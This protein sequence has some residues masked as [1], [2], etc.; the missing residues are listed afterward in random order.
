MELTILIVDDIEINIE[1]LQIEL[2][3]LNFIKKIYTAT[4][5]ESAYNL[6]QS[7][8]IDLVLTDYNMPKMTGVELMKNVINNSNLQKLPEFYFLTGNPTKVLKET[9]QYGNFNI[10]DKPVNIKNL[11]KTIENDFINT[12]EINYSTKQKNKNEKKIEET[13]LKKEKNIIKQ[14]DKAKKTN[15]NKLLNRNIHINTKNGLKIKIFSDY[16]TP[17]GD[18]IEKNITL[19][20]IN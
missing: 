14:L 5:G 1:L 10:F 7:N 16:I 20:D 15:K 13:L 9:L 12:D 8:E 3:K 6:I 19:I 17:K 2:E 11:I 18:I 4:N